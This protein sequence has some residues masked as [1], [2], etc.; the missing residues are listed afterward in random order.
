VLQEAQ[1]IT[2]A[3]KVSGVMS[4]CY[5]AM[6]NLDKAAELVQRTV[7]RLEAAVHNAST[8]NQR[9]LPLYRTLLCNALFEQATL[10]EKRWRFA[11]KRHASPFHARQIDDP[12]R[13]V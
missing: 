2:G 7:P 9:F 3:A 1:D 5:V 6:G 12:F 10:L 8:S 11:F 4:F 13:T